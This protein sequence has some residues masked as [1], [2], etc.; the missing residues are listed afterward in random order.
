MNVH[1]FPCY[2]NLLTVCKGHVLPH[3]P[4]RSRFVPFSG[5]IFCRASKNTK[6]PAMASQ[7]R[8]DKDLKTGKVT[9]SSSTSPVFHQGQ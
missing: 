9:K 8:F 1:D 6:P 7:S 3:L 4:Q 2:L 5:Q